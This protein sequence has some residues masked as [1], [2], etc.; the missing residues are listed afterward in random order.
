M[1]TDMLHAIGSESYH[2][3]GSLGR[4][5]EVT[6]KVIDRS[7][8]TFNWA[9]FLSSVI[10]GSPLLETTACASMWSA[11]GRLSARINWLS[12]DD[13]RTPPA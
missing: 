1:Q 8:S 3:L 9:K 5:A 2:V 6:S 10:S 4:L 7:C 12:C 11:Q 13:R